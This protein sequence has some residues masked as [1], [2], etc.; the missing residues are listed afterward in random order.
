M[1]YPGCEALLPY[2]TPLHAQME[3]DQ[4]EEC[5]ECQFQKVRHKHY[6]QLGPSR[7]QAPAPT[8]VRAVAPVARREV[9][10]QVHSKMGTDV[11]LQRLEAA[12]QLVPPTVLFLQDDLAIIVMEGLLDQI[13]LMRRQHISALEQIDCAAKRKL[14]SP[15][16]S[17]RPLGTAASQSIPVMVPS[18]SSLPAWPTVASTGQPAA[19]A[20]VAH[21]PKVPGA[22]VEGRSMDQQDEE[23]DE[24][25]L[26]REDLKFMDHFESIAPSA[27]KKV[28]PVCW[29]LAGLAHA[30]NVP[31]L[32]KNY[33]GCKLPILIDNLELIDFPADIPARAEFAQLLFMKE[34]IFPAPPTQL[35]VIKLTTDVHTPAQYDGL[36]ATAAVDKGKQRAVPAIED[37]SNYGQSQSEEEEEAEEREL[38]SQ[39]FRRVQRNKKLTKKKANRAKAVAAIMHRA[40]NDFSGRIP[41]DLGVKVW[42]PL[43]VKRLKLCFCRA[44]G[45]CYYYLYLMNTV[46]VGADANHAAAFEFSSGQSAKVPGTKVYQFACWGFP[47]TSYKLERLYKYY[48]NLHVPCCNRI[49]TYMLLSKLKDFTQCC[50]VAL[51]DCTMTLLCSDPAYRDLAN[52]MQCPGDL[53]FAE[54]H[55][56]PSRFL[57]VKD[58]GSTALHMTRSPDS[59]VPF[60]LDQLVQYA[61]IFGRPGMENTWQGI[62]GSMHQQR[63]KKQPSFDEWPLLW[64]V[65]DFI[66]RPQLTISQVHVPDNK[67]RSFSD[68]N[69]IHV[70]LYNHIRVKWVDHAYTYGVV[71]L[72]QQFY[73]PTMSLDI[74]CEVDDEHLKRL[75]QYQD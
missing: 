15:E 17:A 60:D 69:T 30:P 47:G 59:N 11:L 4:E 51:H 62:A 39:H 19:V 37:D 10:P 49:V 48:S 74:F 6:Y 66:M 68:K 27:G 71:Y 34:V 20:N 50:N 45:P 42:G 55:H 13:E 64:H 61:L 5:H 44:L 58:D 7:R 12:E 63:R 24:V 54:K 23:M 32:S 21:E 9:A 18:S 75:R 33:R 8:Y 26:S 40:Q 57:H 41:D 1:P 52:P 22:P 14:S 28:G 65:Q 2:E 31:G 35:T 3:V 25:P 43:N 56:I 16:G 70:L 73:H 46:F 53:P 36:T 29:G 38:A 67:V 72:E